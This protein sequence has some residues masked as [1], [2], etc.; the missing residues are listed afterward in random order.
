[1]FRLSLIVAISLATLASASDWSTR[2]A[3]PCN[4][5]ED[6]IAGRCYQ[7]CRA[8]Y[9]ADGLKCKPTCGGFGRDDGLFCA[10]PA[11]YGRGTGRRGTGRR[12]WFCFPKCSWR[13]CYYG[14]SNCRKN[15]YAIGRFCY[16]KCRKNEDAIGRFCYPKCRS[17]FH[18]V[19]CCVCSPDCPAEFRDNGFTCTKPPSYDRTGRVAIWIGK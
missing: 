5:D 17:G 2:N 18:S 7:K 4:A 11:P 3:Q 1:M 15:E 12:N 16:P 14:C 6:L 13:G 9:E 19:G 10:K 8:N